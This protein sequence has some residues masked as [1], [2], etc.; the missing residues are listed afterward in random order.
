M[1][2]QPNIFFITF[3]TILP[4]NIAGC[5]IIILSLVIFRKLR[6]MIGYNVLMISC[7]DLCFSIVCLSACESFNIAGHIQKGW[8]CKLIAF[9]LMYFYYASIIWLGGLSFTAY[10]MICHNKRFYNIWG[11][12]AVNIICWGIP[13]FFALLPFYGKEFGQ[14]GVKSDTLCLFA[15][16]YEF[17]HALYG[18]CVIGIA[19]VVIIFSYINILITMISDTKNLHDLHVEILK[20]YNNK[21]WIIFRYTLFILG[22]FI[23]WSEFILIAWI[24]WANDI[25]VPFEIWIVF[26]VLPH[27]QGL[28]NAILYTVSHDVHEHWRGWIREH[29]FRKKKDTKIISVNS[30]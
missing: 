24:E 14:Y 30:L 29:I 9:I 1:I 2:N 15:D 4:F 7:A 18:T 27:I 8:S 26:L 19:S 12:I 6:T 20:Q 28:V 13:L 21:W 11:H 3:I 22:Y 5:I 25:T 23:F 10:L 17:Y 16:G